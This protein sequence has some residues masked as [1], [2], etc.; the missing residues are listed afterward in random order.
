MN[1]Y[2]AIKVVSTLMEGDYQTLLGVWSSYDSA[3]KIISSDVN[4]SEYERVKDL[5]VWKYIF[6]GEMTEILEIRECELD[7][8]INEY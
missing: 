8:A 1:L 2:L 4:W 5:N 7:K 3:Y 6:D